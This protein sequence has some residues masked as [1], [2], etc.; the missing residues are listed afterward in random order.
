VRG[1]RVE[2]GS[3]DILTEAHGICAEGVYTYTSSCCLDWKFTT[4]SGQMLRRR[5]PKMPWRGPRRSRTAKEACLRITSQSRR[6]LAER[7]QLRAGQ[8]T[9][10][11]RLV[12]SAHLA[13]LF[14]PAPRLPYKR[15]PMGYLR[16]GPACAAI[17]SALRHPSIVSLLCLSSS[18]TS[19]ALSKASDSCNPNNRFLCAQL[20]TGA[21]LMAS[22]TVAAVK[23]SVRE[24][25]SSLSLTQGLAVLV[26]HAQNILNQ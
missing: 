13:N 23:T 2:G 25:V 3:R 4:A 26:R 20:V 12:A 5:L 1:V 10:H 8:G 22:R 7:A 24:G 18:S 17:L 15:L 19:S 9:G 6:Q 16:E 14:S 11:V 21:V